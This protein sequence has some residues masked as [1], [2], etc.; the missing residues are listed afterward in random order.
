MADFEFFKK[1]FEFR[2]KHARMAQELWISNDYEHTYFK[3]L[4]DLYLVAAVVGFRVDRKA[5][6]D[7]S[8]IEPKSIVPDQMIKEKENLEFMM[9]MMIMLENRGRLS[10]EEC[11]KKAFRGPET[12]REYNDYKNMFNDY[13]RGGVEELYERLIV[14]KA[15]P[16]D[17]Y[18]DDKTA[19]LMNLVE[20]FCE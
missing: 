16:E 13:V 8:P 3:R 20:R 18:R 17:R 2:G 11:V 14:R 6:E 4:M 15:E 9:Q 7:Y 19:N 10:D 12:E 1:E 5:Q